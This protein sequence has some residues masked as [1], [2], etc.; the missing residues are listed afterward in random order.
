MIAPAT[1]ATKPTALPPILLAAAPVVV[2]GA[3]L[4]VLVVP[5]CE[6]VDVA[7][8]GEI[9]TV[10]EV[11]VADI[12]ELANDEVLNYKGNKEKDATH[13][14]TL[15]WFGARMRILAA[16]KKRAWKGGAVLAV[17]LGSVDLSNVQEVIANK[18]VLAPK[19]DM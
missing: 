14:L 6:V 17:Y 15:K 3:V 9:V 1:R 19:L 12:V 2:L 18:P 7:P 16:V 4:D 8:D 13:L 5:R 10:D 11:V